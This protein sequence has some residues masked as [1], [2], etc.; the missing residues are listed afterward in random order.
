[1]PVEGFNQ[2]REKAQVILG[3]Y[4]LLL[5]KGI[6]LIKLKIDSSTS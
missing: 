4:G 6:D 1:M 3:L 5:S 2:Y